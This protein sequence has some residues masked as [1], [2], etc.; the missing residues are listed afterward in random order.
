MTE[1]RRHAM[2]QGTVEV[3]RDIY[4]AF[5]RGDVEAIFGLVHPDAEIY[6]SDQLPWGG[7]YRGHE[8]FGEFLTRLTSTVESK[9]ETGLFIDD[10]DGHVVQV[11]RTRGTVRATGREFDVPETH[12]WTVEGGKAIRY[13]AYVDTAKMREALGL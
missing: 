12:V 3:V 5:A 7:E 13:E 9:V 4:D 2:P 10:E 1:T 8:G 6:Q 11:G